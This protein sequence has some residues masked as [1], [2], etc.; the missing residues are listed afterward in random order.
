[1]SR[2][3]VDTSFRAIDGF[4]ASMRK[5]ETGGAR[6]ARSLKSQFGAVNSTLGGVHNGIKKAAAVTATA[7]VI[8]AAGMAK[9]V[10]VG[11]EFEKTMIGAAAKFDPSIRQGTKAFAELEETA[12]RVG[13]TT[14]FNAQQ[15]AEALKSL[16]S[17]GFGATQAISALP[18]VVD[19]ATAAEID[20]GTAADIAGK[21]LGAFNLKTE[22]AI[23][24]SKNLERVTDVMARTADAT[25]ASMEGL[26]ESIKEGGPVATTAGASMDTFMA[27]AGQLANAGIEGSVAGTTLK[28]MFLTLSAPTKE[29]AAGLAKLGVK[30]KDAKGNLLDTVTILQ[31]LQAATAGMGGADRAGALEGIFGK[32]PIAGISALLDNGIDKV[33]DLQGKLQQAG[34]ATAKMAAIMRDATK[35]DIDGFTSSLEGVSIEIF[36]VARAPIRNIV[37]GTTAWVTANTK[38]VGSKAKEYI[39]WT[40]K[41]LPLIVVWLKT[42]GKGIV[43]FYA[44][45]LAIRAATIALT[46]FQVAS[47]IAAAITTVLSIATS[48]SWI[49]YGL[50]TAALWLDTA[51]TYASAAAKG[52]WN[53][54]QWIGLAAVAALGAATNAGTI[55]TAANTAVTWL[56]SAARTAWTAITGL[57]TAALAAYNAGTLLSTIRMGALAAVTWL[58]NAAS[59][60]LNIVLLANPYVLIGIAVVALIGYLFKLLGGWDLVSEAVKKFGTWAMSYI[61]PVVSKVKALFG[62]VSKTAEALGSLTG[63]NLGIPI[64]GEEPLPGSAQPFRMDLDSAA[65]QPNTTS[66]MAGVSH[67][68]Q[69]STTTNKVELEVKVPQGVSAEAK[70]GGGKNVS[71]KVSN[72]GAGVAPI[73]AH[74]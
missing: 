20:L 55:S 6:L 58:V 10:S 39:A 32:I 8:G 47:R 67:A 68:I 5:M 4:T 7:G 28:N 71:V 13:A 50:M 18:R 63:D 1:M 42:I 37:Q 36:K 25:S 9:M 54:L 72:S 46:A 31:Q 38:L 24:L 30:T 62:F 53:G 41:N 26:F 19:L 44:M 17:A 60:A 45:S 49:M 29:A 34:G 74:G 40:I 12:A 2:F 70:G 27:L 61:D 73:P 16:A 3:S 69:E 51:A 21:S 15:S 57:G 23:Q 66:P 65:M 35:G 11:A 64:P 59:A 33:G 22:D 14:E 52:I 56:A 48:R 43:V